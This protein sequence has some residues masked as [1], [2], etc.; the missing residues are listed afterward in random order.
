MRLAV[1]LRHPLAAGLAIILAFTVYAHFF[2]RLDAGRYLLPPFRP[3]LPHVSN[4][5]QLGSENR[6]IALHVAN[7]EGF[8]DPFSQGT[9]PTAWMSPVYPMVVA[10]L[11]RLLGTDLEVVGLAVAIGQAIGMMF[12]WCAVVAVVRPKSRSECLALLGVL[13]LFLT[14][15]FDYTFLFTHDYFLGALGLAAVMRY[16]PLLSAPRSWR[17]WT[18]WGL[19]GGLST[20]AVPALALPWLLVSVPLLRKHW[21]EM[22]IAVIA[23]VLVLT[24]WTIRNAVVFGRFIPVKSNAPYELY[25]TLR[26]SDTGIVNDDV[27]MHHPGRPGTEQDEY[28]QTGESA[29]LSRKAEQAKEMLANNPG[30]YLRQCVHRLWTIFVWEQPYFIDLDY[31]FPHLLGRVA[32]PLP[33]VGLLLIVVRRQWRRDPAAGVAVL[34]II[35]LAIPYVLVSYYERYEYAFASAKIVLVYY[36]L[37]ALRDLRSRHPA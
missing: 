28:S 20:F 36:G 33:L 19:V 5:S 10:G 32:Y 6:T 34:A 21:R 3:E 31:P 9:G 37:K 13:V 29:Y 24:P 12:I 14:T 4:L 16:A 18:R 15:H 27:L 25:Q 23:F 30:H 35:G 2:S 11:V 22:G 8:A 1:D 26:Y 17:G 7:G